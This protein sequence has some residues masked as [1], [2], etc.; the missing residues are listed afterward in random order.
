MF[1]IPSSLDVFLSVE[2]FHNLTGAYLFDV[3]R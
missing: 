1:M 3:F 2:F